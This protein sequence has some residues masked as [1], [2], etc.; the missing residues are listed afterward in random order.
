[1]IEKRFSGPGIRVNE[2]IVG[3]VAGAVAVPELIGLSDPVGLDRRTVGALAQ[4]LG[5]ILLSLP[6]VGPHNI[7]L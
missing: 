5:G 1:M 4:I 7:L 2:V 3:A 6:E